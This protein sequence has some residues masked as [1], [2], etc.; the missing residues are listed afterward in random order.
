MNYLLSFLLFPYVTRILGPDSYGSVNFVLSTIDYFLIFSAL[1]IEMLGVREIAKVKD[2]VRERSRVFCNL[3]GIN[4]SLMIVVLAVYASAISLVPQFRGNSR[5]FYAGIAKIIF[6]TFI[7]EW[8]FTGLED[9]RFITIRSMIVKGLYV[10]AVFFLVRTQADY[11]MYFYLTVG[12]VAVNAVVNCFYAKSLIKWSWK[13]FREFRFIRNYVI[14]GIYILLSSAYFSF[15]V[16]YLGMVCP[17]AQVG[18]YSASYGL[19]YIILTLFKAYSTVMMPRMNVAMSGHDRAT[20]SRYIGL[21][22]TIISL[23]ALPIVSGSMIMAEPIIH[24][25][26]GAGYGDAVVPMRILMPAVLA[27]CTAQIFVNQIFMPAGYF[28]KLLHASCVGT[29]VALVITFCFVKRLGATGSALVLL[30]SEF[31]VT[32]FYIIRCPEEYL[33]MFPGFRPMTVNV[34]KGIPLVMVIALIDYMVSNPYL[35]VG[36]AIACGMVYLLYVYRQLK[37]GKY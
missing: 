29:A 2:N 16:M 27:V 13:A 36:A 14:L 1:G 22:A 18:Y 34:L 26:S 8:F 11:K 23:I 37:A 15:N 32:V 3:L 10:V 28:R 6:S 5:L 20:F 12:A 33:K 19:Y 4:V 17:A 24:V 31:S 9:F 30:M 21:S 35:S 7:L 25:L